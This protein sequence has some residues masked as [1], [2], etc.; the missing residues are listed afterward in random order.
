MFLQN[1]KTTI[2]TFNQLKMIILYSDIFIKTIGK[3]IN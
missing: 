3:L 2:L 1:V